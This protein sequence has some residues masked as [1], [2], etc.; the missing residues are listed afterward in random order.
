MS[1]MTP[2]ETMR[3]AFRERRDIMLSM[4]EEIPDIKANHPDGA[5][6]VF[7]DVSAYFGRSDG[8]IT[9]HNAD[10]FCDFVMSS[11]YVGLVS[12]SAFGDP[13]CFRLSYAASEAQ[14]RE[15]IRRM[16]DVL[17]RLK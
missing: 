1:D 12:G 11:A 13:N 6:Y 4:L 8:N 15:A 9:F 2:T 5:F 7:P 3:E 17:G 16:K 10:D 14:L